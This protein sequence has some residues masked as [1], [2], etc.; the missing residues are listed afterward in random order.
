MSLNKDFML[1]LILDDRGVHDWLENVKNNILS[2]TAKLEG[3]S[4]SDMAS[5]WPMGCH[6]AYFMF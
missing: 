5:Y 3:R 6:R 2:E 4:C 1:I